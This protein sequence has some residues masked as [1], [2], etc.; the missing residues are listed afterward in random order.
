MNESLIVREEDDEEDEDDEEGM[1][2]LD[3]FITVATS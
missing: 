2:T 3:P 1:R